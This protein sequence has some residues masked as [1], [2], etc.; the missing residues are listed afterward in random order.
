MSTLFISNNVCNVFMKSLHYFESL[1]IV[2]DTEKFLYHV[3]GVL[4]GDQLRK[5]HVKSLNNQIY[6]LSIGFIEEILELPGLGIISYKATQRLTVDKSLEINFLFIIRSLGEVIRLC[7]NIYIIFGRVYLN[8]S[9]IRIIINHSVNQTT[10]K[11]FLI[12]VL[13]FRQY[14]LNR[15]QLNNRNW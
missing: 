1:S 6:L 15:V 12:I 4:M 10:L 13:I 5:L 14:G 2:T 3:I 11:I 9:L 7:K 8:G